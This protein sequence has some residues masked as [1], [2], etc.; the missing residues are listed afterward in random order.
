M[1]IKIC[2]LYP[3]LMN[4]YGDRGNVVTLVRRCR[5]RGISVSVDYLTIGDRLDPDGYDFYFFGGGQ[6]Q[7]QILVA[8]DL[9]RSKGVALRRAIENGAA[10]LSICGGYQLL[11]HF[12]RPFEGPEIPGIGLFDAWTIA[13]HRRK[14]GNVVVRLTAATGSLAN[15]SLVGFE[16]HSGNTFL[17][18]NC[19]PLG[20]VEVGFGNNGEDKTE[21]AVY[22]NVVGCYLHGSVLPKNPHF[23]DH[24]L[25]LALARR[26]GA[27]EL[28]PLDDTIEWEAYRSAFRRAKQTH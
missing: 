4:M 13:S 8:E 20:R 19:Q 14:I 26:H 9:Q 23:A 27:V 1:E 7:E 10:L 15:K 12:F 6:D 16:N 5:P 18:K 28:A 21:G 17:G 25:R 11:G 2:Y 24:L 3:D 22:K